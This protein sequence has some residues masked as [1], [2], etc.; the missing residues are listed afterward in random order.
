MLI[1]ILEISE[2]SARS[3]VS[4]AKLR[5]TLEIFTY[6]AKFTSNFLETLPSSV[7]VELV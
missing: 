5:T 6:T 4:K 1:E 2:T 3:P 7:K